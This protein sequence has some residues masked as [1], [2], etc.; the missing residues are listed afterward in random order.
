LVTFQDQCLNVL[1]TDVQYQ[2][3]K[4]LVTVPY[5]YLKGLVTVQDQCLNV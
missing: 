2:Y 5:Q 3:L 1:I 4:G